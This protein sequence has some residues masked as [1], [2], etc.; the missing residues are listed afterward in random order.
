MFEIISFEFIS[1][2]VITIATVTLVIVTWQYAQATKRY[3]ETTEK[4][5][6]AADTP[7]IRMYL[8]QSSVGSTVYTLDLCI[9]NIGTGF[10]YDVEFSGKLLS[11]QPQHGNI[12]LAAYSIMLN[13]ISHFAP[14]KQCRITLLFQYER[15]NLPQGTFDVVVSYKNSAGEKLESPFTL[16]FN[17]VE[18]YPQIADPSLYS[19]ASCLRFIY[20]H[21][22]DLKKERDNQNQQ[23]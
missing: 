9:H 4:A 14:G 20:G 23:N 19:I 6:K 8:S 21:F 5:L 16:D 18:E 7:N 22:L 11:F 1:T 3:A 13:G 12:P 17:K 15:K 2:V 10:A